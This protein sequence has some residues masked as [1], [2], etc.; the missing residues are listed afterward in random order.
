M[1]VFVRKQGLPTPNIDRMAAEGMRFDRAFLTISSCSPSRA[2]IITGRY[3]HQ[4]DAEQLHWPI[5]KEQITFSERLMKAGYW[6]A[7]VG[8]FH[9]GDA[10]KNRFDK[11][12]EA[13]MSGF[14]ASAKG[15]F[16]ESA[17]GDAKSGASEWVRTLKERPRIS[18][19]S[20]GW[21]RSIR[22]GRMIKRFSRTQRNPK[23]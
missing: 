13:D 8:K 16:Q 2:S 6:T 12:I 11:V 20:C 18:R 5:P 17:K 9:M 21:P 10:M 4:T 23:T 22:I 7:S 1:T 3:P 19:S 15:T 14:I